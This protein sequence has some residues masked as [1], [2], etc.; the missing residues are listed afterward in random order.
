MSLVVKDIGGLCGEVCLQITLHLVTLLAN[1]IVHIRNSVIKSK[2]TMPI[3]SGG[4]EHFSASKKCRGNNTLHS[5][6]DEW[7][8][9]AKCQVPSNS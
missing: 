5:E 9:M 4:L 3:E 2:K 6:L 1:C 8:W 7:E